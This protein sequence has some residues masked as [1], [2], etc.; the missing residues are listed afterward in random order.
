MFISGPGLSVR[1]LEGVGFI[2]APL[3][4][5]FTVLTKTYPEERVGGCGQKQRKLH[6]LQTKAGGVKCLTSAK[7]LEDF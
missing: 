7:E 2:G 4:R 6:L 3:N 1:L 5:G